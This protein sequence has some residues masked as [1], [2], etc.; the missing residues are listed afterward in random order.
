MD[1]LINDTKTTFNKGRYILDSVICANEVLHGV[2]VSKTKGVIFKLDFENAYDLINW[3]FLQ[4][5]I[6][7]RDFG[8]KFRQWIS[9]SLQGSRTC[10]SVNGCLG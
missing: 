1:F 2:R 5:A 3:E 8:S 9:D 4:E 6:L 7:A 10:I